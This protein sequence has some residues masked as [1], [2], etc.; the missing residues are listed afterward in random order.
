MGKWS[1]FFNKEE[2]PTC[3][4]CEKAAVKKVE[5]KLPGYRPGG[6]IRNAL[7]KYGLGRITEY[8]CTAC[9]CTYRP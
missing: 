8:H 5:Y 3:P 2:L 4:N 7:D 6:G 1:R 9:G